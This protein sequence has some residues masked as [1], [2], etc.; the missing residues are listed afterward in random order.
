MDDVPDGLEE[1]GRRRERL[2]VKYLHS[3]RKYFAGLQRMEELPGHEPGS[4]IAH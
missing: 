4:R 1:P 3:V 2:A